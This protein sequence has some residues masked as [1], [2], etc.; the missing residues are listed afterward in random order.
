M[1]QYNYKTNIKGTQMKKL[2]YLEAI[3]FIMTIITDTF[4]MDADTQTKIEERIKKDNVIVLG[5]S[6]AKYGFNWKN[7]DERVI[8]FKEDVED[9]ITDSLAMI[10]V[11][12][13][14][15]EIDRTVDADFDNLYDDD[16]YSYATQNDMWYLLEDYD[17]V[18]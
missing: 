10:E 13:Y 4:H 16:I 5:N 9:I 18:A 8:N 6:I 7:R 15:I 12:D 3:A 11:S 14:G 2:T 17:E 1:V